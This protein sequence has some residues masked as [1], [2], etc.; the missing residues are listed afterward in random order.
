MQL[1]MYEKRRDFCTAVGIL[2]ENANYHNKIA[3]ALRLKQKNEDYTN[4]NSKL[5]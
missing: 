2:I 4:L 3:T 1:Q 5:K